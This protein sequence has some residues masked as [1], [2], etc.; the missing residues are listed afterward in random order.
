LK[1][2]DEAVAAFKEAIA[3]SPREVAYYQSLGFTLDGMGK[4]ED[5]IT[6]FKKAVALERRVGN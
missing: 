3:I 2:Y 1:Q 5:A 4:H 6:Y